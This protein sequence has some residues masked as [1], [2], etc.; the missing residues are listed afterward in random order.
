MPIGWAVTV[1][2]LCV[3]VVILVI[4]V[5]G[6]SRQVTRVLERAAAVQDA[7]H[8][9]AM[10]GPVAGSPLPHFEARGPG[11]QVTSEQLRGR[12]ALLLFLSVGCR[13]CQALADELNRVELGDLT[14]QLV[15]I[16]GPGGLQE[17]GLPETVL[18]LTE[19]AGEVTDALS[20]LGT[21]FAIAVDPD[22][23]VNAGRPVNKV[24]E[25]AGL[26]AVIA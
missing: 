9:P 13:P 18:V 7:E 8:E 24:T 23:I 12:P 20:V 22:G 19:Q 4:I 6:L 5:L 21:P 2:V 25:L 16:T 26:A 1:V 10:Q 15:V 11:G 17:L 3:A 14:G